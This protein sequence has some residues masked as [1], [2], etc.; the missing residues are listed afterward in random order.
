MSPID[1]DRWRAAQQLIKAHGDTAEYQAGVRA[2]SFLKQ[3]DLGGFHL[4]QDVALKVN[5]LQ[6][7]ALPNP[8]SN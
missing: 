5:H 6:K 8:P 4:W 3:G 7:N 2:A 1:L